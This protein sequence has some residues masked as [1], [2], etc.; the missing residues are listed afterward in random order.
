MTCFFDVCLVLVLLVGLTERRLITL[1]KPT[2]IP[3]AQYLM[4]LLAWHPAPPS[5]AKA[6]SRHVLRG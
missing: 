3:Y 6:V 2:D 4:R 1:A 5:V